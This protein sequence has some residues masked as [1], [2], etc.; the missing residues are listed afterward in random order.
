[1]WSCEQVYATPRPSNGWYARRSLSS[2]LGPVSLGGTPA[3][4]QTSLAQF[5]GHACV[6]CVL[7]AW[8]HV[9]LRRSVFLECTEFALI[10]IVP[11]VCDV[12]FPCCV[13]RC[14]LHVFVHSYGF[15]SRHC[16]LGCSAFVF[17]AARSRPAPCSVSCHASRV[18]NHGCSGLCPFS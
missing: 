2:F 18:F 9:V 13:Q 6:I 1:M 5:L 16:G 15:L 14:F 17:V 11:P 10:A 7:L 4:P 12:V 8:S 3:F